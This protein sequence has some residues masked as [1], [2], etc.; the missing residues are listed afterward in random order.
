MKL[1]VS[2]KIFADF[3]NPHIA[4]IVGEGANNQVDVSEIHSKTAT[5]LDEIRQNYKSETLSQEPKIAAWR[6]AYRKFGAKPKEYPSSIEAL[7]KRVLKG[8]DIGAINPL[9]D[10]YNYI[11]L[12]HMLPVGGEDLE[13]MQG[14][15]RLTLAG[16]N[17]E[18]VIV[19]GKPEPQAPHKGEVI[20]RDDLG[21]ICRRWNWRE[22]SR[23]IL[24]EKTKN[25]ILVIEALYPVSNDEL[26]V[27]QKELAE[28]ARDYSGAKITTHIIDKENLEITLK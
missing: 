4:V 20:Y 27:A 2:Q 7:Y 18:A 26:I 12:K 3:K 21:T 23:T 13:Q 9:V 11:S 17:E 22:V 16:D 5:L 19:L 28:L 15:L 25:F 6:E 24:T 1:R 14:D 10:I 8:G